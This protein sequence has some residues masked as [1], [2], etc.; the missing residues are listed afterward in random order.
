MR[1]TPVPAQSLALYNTLKQ[2]PEILRM[3]AFMAHRNTSVYHHS[4]SV[5]NLSLWLAM[6]LHIKR[7]K[8][9][10]LILAAM[11]HDFYLY[12]Y[13]GHR[14]RSDGWHAWQHPALA[15]YNAEKLFDLDQPAR[16]AIRAHMF[17]GTLFHMPLYLIGWIVSISDKTC[18]ILELLNSNRMLHIEFIPV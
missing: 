8:L 13:H 9:R 11:L 4:V 17:P 18:A 14:I 7:S 1:Q 16:N 15:L 2:H 10:S 12:D 3:Q 6:K 5:V